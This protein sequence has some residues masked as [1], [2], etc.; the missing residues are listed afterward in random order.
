MKRKP[1]S[2]QEGG[3]LTSWNPATSKAD[4]IVAKDGSGNYK[5]INEAIVALARMGGNRPER[6]IIYV[7]SGVYHEKVDIGRDLKNVMLVGDGMDNTVVTAS[8]N[9]QDGQTTFSSATFG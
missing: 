9:V 7:K 6:A 4:L 1:G 3:P 2:N 5:T 8:G